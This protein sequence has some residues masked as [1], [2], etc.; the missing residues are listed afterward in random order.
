MGAVPQDHSAQ[1]E[2]M[3]RVLLIGASL[4]AL[5]TGAALAETAVIATPDTVQ[6]KDAPQ[7]GPGA[8][9]AVLAG[10][11]D[12]SGPYVMRLK[13]PA[14]STVP[15]HTHSGTENVTVLSGNLDLG[16]GE[17]LDKSKGQELVAE[18]YFLMPA[19]TPH[20]AWTNSE[21]IVQVHGMGPTDMQILQPASGTSQ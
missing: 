4:I 7:F 11:P 17:K 6:W 1:E 18:S 9:M 2:D 15:A 13:L 10:D 12:K 3:G 19:H 14:N 8:K 5:T 20:F 16:L 21:T